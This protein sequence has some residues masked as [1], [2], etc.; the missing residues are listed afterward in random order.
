MY[1]K[2][3]FLYNLLNEFVRLL[4]LTLKFLLSLDL[5]CRRELQDILIGIAE[6]LHG[7]VDWRAQLS[8]AD[9]IT[10]M[11]HIESFLAAVL[12]DLAE[13]FIVD[14]KEYLLLAQF[15]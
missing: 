6:K 7:F 3:I 10:N 4:H 14:D 1:S 9:Q 15:A 2:L 11:R 8:L 5:L 12:V 13:L